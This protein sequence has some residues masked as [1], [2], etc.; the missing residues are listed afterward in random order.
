MKLENYVPSVETCR[1]LRDAGLV[2]E[3]IYTWVLEQHTEDPQWVLSG[4]LPQGEYQYS[5]YSVGELGTMLSEIPMRLYPHQLSLMS[6]M[7]SMAITEA[8][9]RSKLL[10]FFIENGMMSHD[11]MAMWVK[12]GKEKMME[13]FADDGRGAPKLNEARE[14]AD[15]EAA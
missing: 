6:A 10:L 1:K 15:D 11:W 14:K 3:S 2:Q 5:A 4:E 9:F 7:G 8:E 12:K 13:N